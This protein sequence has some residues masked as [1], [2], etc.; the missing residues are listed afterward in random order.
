MEGLGM[1]YTDSTIVRQVGDE[2]LVLDTRSDLVHHL[3]PTASVIWRLVQDGTAPAVIVSTL[4]SAFDVDAS[5][6]ARD[7]DEML[8][9]FRDLQLL[10]SG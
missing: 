9:K 5:I 2:T 1:Q 4:A 10:A 6:A 3:N 8:A 7:V